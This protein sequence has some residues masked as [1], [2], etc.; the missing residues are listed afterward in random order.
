MAWSSQWIVQRC[1]EQRLKTEI[2]LRKIKNIKE[3]WT[4]DEDD[5]ENDDEEIEHDF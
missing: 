1:H 4:D 3:R 5:D 2:L